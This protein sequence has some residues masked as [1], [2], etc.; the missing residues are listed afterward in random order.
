MKRHSVRERQRR[1]GMAE[2]VEGPGGDASGLAVPR[3][4]LGQPLRVDDAAERVGEH[5]V[6]VPIGVGGEVPH[7]FVTSQGSPLT[8][9][10]RALG[11]G[12]SAGAYAAA[13]ELP[14]ELADAL[15]LTLLLSEDPGRFDRACVRWVGRLILE[16]PG[17][18][19][20]A[21]HLALAALSSVGRGSAAG[22][23]AIAELFDELGA[24]RP[25]DRR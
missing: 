1:G 10:R 6:V 23:H 16:V 19:A 12:D 25:L 24:E 13:T 9:F 11:A 15:A 21:A 14:H 17:L 5:E 18:P 2:D 4:P 7:T 22:A 20:E 3:E 8:R